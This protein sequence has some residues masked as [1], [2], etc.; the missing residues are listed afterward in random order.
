MSSTYVQTLSASPNYIRLPRS[1]TACPYTGLSRSALDL[2]TRPQS[3]NNF[4]PPV[5]SKIFRQ[6][7]QKQGI[8]LINYESLMGYLDKLPNEQPGK[9]AEKDSGHAVA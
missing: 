3:A 1:G 8:R 4:R 5:E 9:G 2:V 7:G 6:A